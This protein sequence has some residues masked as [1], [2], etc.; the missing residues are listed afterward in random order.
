MA[1]VTITNID[2]DDAFYLKQ[3]MAE[4]RTRVKHDAVRPERGQKRFKPEFREKCRVE[5]GRLDRLLGAVIIDAA[6]ETSGA[7]PYPAEDE[8]AEETHDRTKP[9][10]PSDMRRE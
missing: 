1:N 10:M 6:D 8:P 3:L 5:G 2:L 9:L 4:R 7:K